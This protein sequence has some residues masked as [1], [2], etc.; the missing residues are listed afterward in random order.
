MAKKKKRYQRQFKFWLN[1]MSRQDQKIIEDIEA[2]KDERSF[3][4]AIRD[5]LRLIPS[6]MRGETNVLFELFPAIRDILYAQM[7]ADV[8]E[9]LNV[10]RSNEVIQHIIELKGVVSQF[11]NQPLL[12]APVTGNITMRRVTTEEEIDFEVVKDENYSVNVAQNFLNSIGALGATKQME[13]VDIEPEP[14]KLIVPQFNAPSFDDEGD[15][16]LFT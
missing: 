16:D 2:L 4:Q 6:L 9:R 11:K 1:A 14:T 10:E 3:T 5:G 12:S 8:L 13:A 7:E 15:L